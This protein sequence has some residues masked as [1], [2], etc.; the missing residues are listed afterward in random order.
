[1]VFARKSPE[2]ERIFVNY[3]RQDSAGYAGRLADSLGQYFGEDRVFRD[4]TGIDYGHDF[5]RV[6]EDRLADSGAL[7]VVIGPNWIRTADDKGNRRLDDPGDY[8]TLEIAAALRSGVAVVP[9]L[10]DG[11]AMPQE[12]DLPEAL[13]EMVKRNA[14]TITDERWEHD[15]ARLA[16]V[17]AIDV[18]GSVVQRRLDLLRR[19]AIFVPFA[20]VA[21]AT[22][23]FCRAVARWA[24]SGGEGRLRDW[25]YDPLIGSL[26]FMAIII[27]GIATLLAVRDMERE[28]RIYGWTAA[29]TAC[30]G[31]VATFV[32]YIVMNNAAPSWS[33]IVTYGAA[34]VIIAA[35]LALI[36]LAGFRAK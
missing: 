25:G 20:A 28:K 19:V 16:K 11:A 7:I 10:I 5:E 36:A 8:V 17:I 12:A 2:R 24:Q 6:I 30:V 31:T 27:A 33:L 3:R 22:P 26:P 18:P 15:V 23:F 29:A 32:F 1:M 14:M 4:V 13:R 35:L 21:I 9:V 34:M